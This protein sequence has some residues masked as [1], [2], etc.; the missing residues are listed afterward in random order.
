MD[1]F[2]NSSWFL[3]IIS[4]LL[5]VLLYISI[6]VEGE[7]GNLNT[8]GSF[9]S[10]VP[11]Q[12]EDVKITAIYDSENLTVSG[13][14][15]GV[16]MTLQG[17]NSIVK[18][19]ILEKKYEVYVDLSSLPLGT[20]TVPLKYKNISDKLKVKLKPAQVTVTIQEKITKKFPVEVKYI[21]KDKIV[22][23]YKL[24]DP[25]IKPTRVTVTGPKETVDDITSIRAI[26]DLKGVNQT[27]SKNVNIRAYNDDGEEVPIDIEPNVVNVTIPVVTPSKVVSL[28]V[29]QTG[30]L[31]DNLELVSI[32]V[33]PKNVTIFGPLHQINSIGYLNGPEIDLST[34]KESTVIEKDIPLIDGIEKALP[35]KVEIKIT[36]RQIEKKTIKNVP[37]ELT[38]LP[39]GYEANFVNPSDGKMDITIEGEKSIVDSINASDFKVN[40]NVSSY[41]AGQHKVSLQI[42][43]PKDVQ[44]VSNL[45]EATIDIQ[46]QDNEATE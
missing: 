21:N 17:S 44:L 38:G 1:K 29:K 24:E 39:S 8:T 30:K 27:F 23:G 28:N 35:S 41:G 31:S 36:V 12:I 33:D 32:E 4:L 10:D 45:K 2:I 6:A 20:H 22:D 25:L 9:F 3:K 15:S 42:T 40:V 7:V 19:T 26:V 43:A 34:I 16:D 37:I 46:K 5:A 13:I 11:E 18:S 14:P